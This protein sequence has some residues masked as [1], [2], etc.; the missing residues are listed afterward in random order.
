M[1]PH[2]CRM[3]WSKWASVLTHRPPT[4]FLE[5]HPDVVRLFPDYVDMEESYYK[6]TGVWP[7]MHII[8]LQKRVLDQ[9]PWV[10][11]NLYNA[12]LASKN[13]SVER[14]MDPAVSR[15]PV[16][17]LPTTM[18]KMQDFFG[19][20]SLIPYKMPAVGADIGEFGEITPER[21]RLGG[22]AGHELFGRLRDLPYPTVAAIN[23][24]AVGGGVEIAPACDHRASA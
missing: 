24:A 7:I 6:R 3:R 5:H 15:Y 2:F 14:L 4:C 16:A 22:E 20:D 19:G 18:R 13:R 8:A 17:W 21:A 1:H 23:G 12:F 9:N 10:A 11:R